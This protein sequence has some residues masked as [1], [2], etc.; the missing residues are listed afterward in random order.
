MTGYSIKT[1]GGVEIFTEDEL[2]AYASRVGLDRVAPGRYSWL[3]V[4]KLLAFEKF[5]GI[6]PHTI[7]NEVAALESGVVNLGTKPATEFKKLP[8]KGLW[9]KH[10]FSAH[11]IGQNL[12]NQHANGR[13]EALIEKVM[14]PAKYPVVTQELINKVASAVVSDAMIA[15][16]AQKKITGEWIVFA[17][18][19]GQ[20]YYLTLDKHD[21]DDLAI[22][23]QIA[24]I[25]FPQ[26]PFLDPNQKLGS[27]S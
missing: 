9:H 4:L 25:C 5:N 22:Y 1:S 7:I 21:T 2:R 10:F 3:F 24:K 14:D 6:D 11:F 19:A 23:N 15:R 20:N 17:K 8:L 18:H 13:L 27:T 16:G 12:I 26:F